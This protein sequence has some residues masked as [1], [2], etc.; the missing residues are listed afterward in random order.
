MKRLTYALRFH[1]P[2]GQQPIKAAGLSLVTRIEDG[3]VDGTLEPLQGGQ[4]VLDLEYR[5]NHDE[6][7][8]FEWGSVTFGPPGASALTFSSIGAGVLPGPVD[9][10]G[11]RHGTVAYQVDSG[12]GALAGATGIITSNF[13]VNLDTN[14]LV[15]THLAILRLP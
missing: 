5:T 12:T 10:E 7:L 3:S 4:A 2:P 1:R 9:E 14:E 6:T 11:F 13:L 15:D 8:F